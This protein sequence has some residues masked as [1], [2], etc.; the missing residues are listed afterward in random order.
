MSIITDLENVVEGLE[1][2]TTKKSKQLSNEYKNAIAILKDEKKITSCTLKH[3]INDLE[4][5]SMMDEKRSDEYEK[6]IGK[7]RNASI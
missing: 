2:E 6:A 3:V 5:S 1:S 4:E 7:L